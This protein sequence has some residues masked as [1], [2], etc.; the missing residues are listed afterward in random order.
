[1]D[2]ITKQDDFD[3]RKKSSQVTEYTY[4][5]QNFKTKYRAALSYF[6]GVRFAKDIFHHNTQESLKDFVTKFNA[7]LEKYIVTKT[8]HKSIRDIVEFPCY[9]KY[10]FDISHGE[11]EHNCHLLKARTNDSDRLFFYVTDINGSKIINLISICENHEDQDTTI[12]QLNSQGMPI[13]SIYW[14]LE[15]FLK[16]LEIFNQMTTTSKHFKDLFD[17]EYQYIT[18]DNQQYVKDTASVVDNLSIV[19]NA[20]SGKSIIGENWLRTRMANSTKVLYLTMSESLV[21]ERRFINNIGGDPASLMKKDNKPDTVQNSQQLKSQSKDYHY[22]ATRIS[23]DE[24]SKIDFETVFGFMMS[25]ARKNGAPENYYMNANESYNFFKKMLTESTIALKPLKHFPSNDDRIQFL[26]RKIHGQ[27]KGCVPSRDKLSYS[28]GRFRVQPLLSEKEYIQTER[29]AH[30]NT[31]EQDSKVVSLI[32]SKVYAAYKTALKK[33]GRADDNDLARFILEKCQPDTTYSD[34]FIDECQDLTE[35]ELLALFYIFKNAK[36]RLMASDRCQIVQPTY[37]KP[38]IMLQLAQQASKDSN[39]EATA[40]QVRFNHNYRSG[41]ELV[42]FQNSIIENINSIFRLTDEEIREIISFTAK[43]KKPVWITASKENN[44]LLQ[45]L[46]SEL[47]KGKLQLI[48]PYSEY[49]PEIKLYC[50]AFRDGDKLQE[51]TA[52]DAVKCKGMEYRAVLLW[53]ILGGNL[54]PDSIYTEWAWRYFYV[55]A[56][57]AQQTL[58]IYEEDDESGIAAFLNK[59]AEK[60]IIDKCSDLEEECSNTGKT[61]FQYIWS[62]L[63]E[64]A[65]DDYL[66]QAENLI[67]HEEYEEAIEIYE[68]LNSSH[69]G[70]YNSEIARCKAYMLIKER[71]FSKAMDMILEKPDEENIRRGYIKTLIQHAAID[72]TSYLT[73]LLYLSNGESSEFKKIYKKFSTKYGVASPTDNEIAVMAEVLSKTNPYVKEIGYKFCFEHMHNLTEK[74]KSAQNNLAA[75]LN[76]DFLNKKEA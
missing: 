59:A 15:A 51:H 46:L 38:G 18:D 49:K 5:N 60:G 24:N 4:Q 32:Y 33:A 73:G 6:T 52:T 23:M 42:G 13:G 14:P 17:M 8:E 69:P 65:D 39:T 57:R 25:Y 72:K 3:L 30:R 9:I 10:G 44:V 76:P 41:K 11:M 75:L 47:Q 55:G 43:G 29:K 53:K 74:I 35:I 48:Y 70:M 20:G 37:F 58:L 22:E 68:M 26:W 27:L 56:T 63:E 40:T 61:W 1:M 7:L 64:F 28:K 21:Q 16:R 54:T 66:E 36:H 50:K 67:V 71:D 19:G 2:N 62:D 12:R 45:R 31:Q 34:V